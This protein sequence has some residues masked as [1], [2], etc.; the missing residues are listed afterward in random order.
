MKILHIISHFISEAWYQENYMA[1]QSVR[2][3]HEVFV[4]SSTYQYPHPDR[5]KQKEQ[6]YEKGVSDY[7]GVKIIRLPS[8]FH[9][10]GRVWLKGLRRE[11]NKINPD[12]VISHSILDFN[13]LRI[14]SRDVPFRYI[15]DDH[16]LIGLVDTSIIGKSFYFLFRLLFLKKLLSK[17]DK[18]VAISKGCIPTINQW[19]GVPLNRIDL[20]PLGADPDTFRCK[21]SYRNEFRKKY[22][23]DANSFVIIY[24]GKMY[25]EK[26]PHLI[27]EALKIIKPQK[28]VHVIFIGSIVE[29]YKEQFNQ[30]LKTC[31]SSYTILSMLGRDEL[32]KA[33]CSSDLAIWPGA[34][35]ISTL[36]ASACGLP[37]ICDKELEERLR[38]KNGIG[39][40]FGSL[41]EL[42]SAIKYLLEN[43]KE[44]KLMGKRGRDYIVNELSWKVIT[45]KFL[46]KSNSIVN[47]NEI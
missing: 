30:S 31:P 44:R 17:A 3:G 14:L 23:I 20:I 39:I 21:S 41:D 28:K 42:V 36:E 37:V 38:N 35:T 4:I 2:D 11:I 32:V 15:V 8:L 25:E 26:K 1:I 22:S 45:N 7:H 46:E 12:V 29:N 10:R 34:A 5:N 16:Q 40:Q 6:I 18:I 27:I 47:K 33:F 24:T 43:E 19:F 9:I 13:V